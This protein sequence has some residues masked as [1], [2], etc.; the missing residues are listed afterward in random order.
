MTGRS[1]VWEALFK[2]C[3]I[4]RVN[5]FD[6][7]DDLIKAFSYLP[8]MKGGRSVGIISLSGGIGLMAMDACE[9]SAGD[10]GTLTRDEGK[11]LSDITPLA[12]HK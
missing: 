7:I 11:N 1:E 5:D 3:G 4:I 6:E 2:Q 8:L 10:T 9:K 12:Y